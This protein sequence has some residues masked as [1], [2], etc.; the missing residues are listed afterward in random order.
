[1]TDTPEETAPFGFRTVAEAEKQG[2]VNEVFSKVALRYD[3]MND[4]MSGGLHRLWKDDFVTL[5]SPPRGPRDFQVIDVAGGT[6]DI[7]FRIARAGGLGTHITIADISPEMVAEGAKRAGAEGLTGQCHFTVGNAESL[8][9]PDKSFDAYTIAFGIRNVTHIDRALQEAY[10][11]LKPG[12]KF[13]CLEFSH[14]DVPGLAAIYDAYSFTTIPA[15]G[16]VVTGDGA[17]YRYLVE[18]IRT[19]PEPE[20]FETMIAAAGFGHVG[21]RSLS[22][23]IVAIHWGWRI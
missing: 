10:R 15:I 11:V 5:L 21:H 6:G 4:L 9:F 22:G 8:A 2:L 14:V 23:S 18:S 16:K 1:M 17:P 13:Q 12:G 7:A 20:K 3:Q 19:F